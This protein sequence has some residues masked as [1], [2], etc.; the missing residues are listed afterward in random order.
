MAR[1]AGSEVPGP[2]A[3]GRW[4]AAYD[5]QGWHRTGSSTDVRSARWLA[6]IVRGLGAEPA[7]EAFPFDR[8]VLRS[9]RVVLPAGEMS[10]VPLYDASLPPLGGVSG[11]LGPLGSRADIGVVDISPTAG[12]DELLEA[13]R[14]GAHRAI[15][16]VTRGG[17][18][19][20]ALRNAAS[21]APFGPPVVQVGSQ[22]GAKMRAAAADGLWATVRVDGRRSPAR[23]VNVSAAVGGSAPEAE[24]VIVLTPRSGWWRCAAERGGG[25]ACWLALVAAAVGSPGRR[26]MRF[27]ATSGHELDFAGVHAHLAA[28][29]AELGAAAWVHLGA[30]IGAAAGTLRVS[31]SQAEL[32]RAAAHALVS[33]G[34]RRPL[35]LDTPVGEG[36]SLG[37]A[38]ARFVSFVGT[39]AHFHLR[40]DRYPENVDADELAATAAG[41]VTLVGR[42]AS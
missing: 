17:S 37:R 24:P 4:I 34:A 5:N 16:A 27:L 30:N 35:I 31:S 21:L 25:L 15:V 11:L 18:P 20:L 6:E 38:G 41:L 8:L 26:P 42:L 29:P 14:E 22:H 33:A 10:G 39:N 9:A 7:F 13:R 23:M 1:P 40:S 19:G 2:E 12:P 3:L 32:A 36:A 28:H